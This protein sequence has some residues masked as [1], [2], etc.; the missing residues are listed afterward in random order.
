MKQIVLNGKE[1]VSEQQ[2]HRLLAQALD[3]P[4]WYGG[5]LDA[6]FD[7]LTDVAEDTEI[8]LTEADGFTKKLGERA[9]LVLAVLRDAAAENSRL[10]ISV[11]N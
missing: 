6:L 2:L 3:L 11:E 8:L 9:A 5:N 4:E 1:I 7:C 10:K